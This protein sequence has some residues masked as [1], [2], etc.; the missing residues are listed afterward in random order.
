MT[1]DGFS[2]DI[3]SGPTTILSDDD[4]L[5]FEWLRGDF[6]FDS[7]IYSGSL[8]NKGA[9]VWEGYF[10]PTDSGVHQIL[11]TTDGYV[12][13]EFEDDNYTGVGIN[14]YKTVINSGISTTIN[15]GTVASSNR[16]NIQTQDIPVLG[17]GLSVTGSNISPNTVIESRQMNLRST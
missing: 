17:I 12:K 5:V 6:S 15:V 2:D 1:G 16:I 7:K 9:L 11:I 3:V 14:T 4:K 13:L 10:V 8:S